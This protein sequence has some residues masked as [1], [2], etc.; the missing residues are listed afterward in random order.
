MK[1]REASRVVT[2]ASALRIMASSKMRNLGKE[3]GW[4]KGGNR[5]Q[6]LYFM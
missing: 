2:Q 4:G 6:G 1:E 5:G 3:W